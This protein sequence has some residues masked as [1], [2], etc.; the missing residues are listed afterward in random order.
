MSE[1]VSWLRRDARNAR[2]QARGQGMAPIESR[3]RERL[4]D[5]VAHARARSPYYARLY[6][7]LPDRVD[8][9]TLLP[10]T[11]KK[12]LMGHFDDWV[13]DRRITLADVTAFV[14]DPDMIG[15]RFLDRYSIATTSGTSG[16]RGVFVLDDRYQR[17]A[18][19]LGLVAYGSLGV[20]TVLR[21]LTRGFRLALV[22]AT[23]GHYVSFAG[24][25]QA[26]RESAWRRR[27]LRAFSVHTPM[28]EFV[29]RLN[30]FRPAAVIGYASVI[31]LLAAEQEAGRLR[32]D[33]V[34][35]QPAGD[36]MTAR[37]L[38]RIAAAFGT[39][40]RPIYS[41]TE[42]TYLSNGCAHG[43]YHVNSDW[44]VLEPVDADHRPT[45]PGQLS[46]TVLL[47]NLA[48]RVQPFLRYDLGDAVQLRPDPCPCGNPLPGIRV[49]GRAGDTLSFPTGNGDAVTVAPMAVSTLFDRTPGIELF[50][51]EQTTP[52]TLRVR[53]LLADGAEADRV[54]R[55][56]E[57]EL[58]RLLTDHTLD[59]VTI[60]RAAEPPR[61]EPGGGKYRA[62]I[63]HR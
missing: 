20:G 52:T 23:G 13:T 2:K 38:D 22:G 34:L 26:T 24:Y 37:D 42:C 53:M 21:M 44:A 18:G 15:R 35:V 61:Q 50:Q 54:W 8:D 55:T 49:R 46:H 58:R 51:I 45:P 39:T 59:T 4:A 25:T 12:T 27:I 56:V 6:D 43:W 31:R 32:I 63:P 1:S 57:T 29:A 62:V 40:V 30:A 60:E 47:S 33:P 17:V 3:Q 48:N 5:I 7:G 10:V 28:P 9:P 14:D 11:D 36:T 19:A 41:C 16:H